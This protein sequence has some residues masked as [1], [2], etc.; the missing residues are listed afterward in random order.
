MCDVRGRSVRVQDANMQDILCV[1]QY[2]FAI[3]ER[4]W[5]SVDASCEW[6]KCACDC[7][8]AREKKGGMADMHT[9]VGRVI[10]KI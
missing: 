10:N 2:I 6:K 3:F 8:G 4:L 5:F 9:R 1:T 7:G